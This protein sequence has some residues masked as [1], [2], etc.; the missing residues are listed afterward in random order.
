MEMVICCYYQKV[1]AGNGVIMRKMI[2]DDC[3]HGY[4]PVDHIDGKE[5][6]FWDFEWIY[7][8]D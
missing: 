7:S 1:E 2:M 6:K 4:S 3:I 5:V 8:T